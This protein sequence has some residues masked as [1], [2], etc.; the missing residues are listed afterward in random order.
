MD[1][2]KRK[3]E[4]ERKLIKTLNLE[5]LNIKPNLISEFVITH[6]DKVPFPLIYDAEGGTETSHK[7]REDL[8][9]LIGFEIGYKSKMEND[10]RTVILFKTIT[11][12]MLKAENCLENATIGKLHEI[13][14]TIHPDAKIIH[15]YLAALMWYYHVH[16][17][18][19]KFQ[20]SEKGFNIPDIQHLSS[21]EEEDSQDSQFIKWNSS[22]GFWAYLDKDGGVGRIEWELPIWCYYTQK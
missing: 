21:C 14:K 15:E 4:I 20:L 10:I 16:Y 6:P 11:K 5:E 2:I 12:E 18:I 8:S 22:C 1:T 13:A 9:N 19:M 17:Y 7:V 3:F